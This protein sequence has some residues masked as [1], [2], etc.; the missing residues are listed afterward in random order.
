MNQITGEIAVK[1]EGREYALMLGLR[2]ISK[3]QAKYGRDLAVIRD[4]KAESDQ[5][6]DISVFLD[7]VDI[8]LERHHPDAPADLAESLLLADFS[9]PGQLVAAAFPTAEPAAAKGRGG[10]AGKKPARR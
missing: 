3:L 4:M 2:G 5:L 1:H 6:P 9:L 7:I 10:R 8:A